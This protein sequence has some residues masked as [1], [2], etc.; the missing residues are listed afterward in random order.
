MLR[1]KAFAE[2]QNWKNKTDKKSLIVS[3]ARQ[4][5]KTYIIREFGKEYTSFIEL[6]FLEQP[7]LCKIF[8]NNLTV[9]SILMGIRLSKPDV[10]IVEGET[11]LFLDE[12]QECP[13]AITSLKFM[14]EDSR[15]D[16]IS[17]G[18]ALGMA[19]NR[20][21]SFPV[22]YVEYLDMYSLD[23]EEFLWAMKVEEDIIEHVK[24]HFENLTEVEEVIDKKFTQFLR[25]YMA[26]GGMPEVVATFQE[27]SDYRRANE[28]QKRIYRDYLADIARFALP[29]E[30]LKAE[31]CYRSIPSQLMKDNHKFQYGIVESKG[32]ARK[33]ENSVDWLFSAHMVVDVKNVGYVEYPLQLHEI[34]DNFRLY[35]TDIG[36]LISTFDYSIIPAILEDEEE[37]SHIIL[38][39][40]KG[41]LYEALIA[42]ILFKRGYDKL[43]FYRNEAGTAEMEF[44]IE[45]ETGVVPV[46]VKA[47]KK[48][49]KTL[50]N[51]LKKEDLVKGYKLANQNVGVVGKKI[52]LPL[53]MAIWIGK[54]EK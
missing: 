20:T 1:R 23:F 5:G 43:H 2:L 17:S 39:T 42:D 15:I 32:T 21:T 18:S 28:I 49:A 16:V 11:L 26:L 36:L 14:T 51:L 27:E 52:T 29:S 13:E 50:D 35:P 48:K 10:S 40:A 30:K 19:Y 22:G 46:E 45:D 24:G 37:S 31:K 25:Q 44:L 54:N 53:Y 4:I 9:D 33:F 34:D 38:K 3:G 41:G 47:G 6:N 8:R 7:E 12:I